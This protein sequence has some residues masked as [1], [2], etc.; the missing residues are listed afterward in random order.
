MRQE[1]VHQLR[2]EAAASLRRHENRRANG[3][4]A[5]SVLVGEADAG[6][7]CWTDWIASQGRSAIDFD[8]SSPGIAAAAV[9]AVWRSHD[10]LSA[11]FR[12]LG[13]RTGHDAAQLRAEWSV[14]TGAEQALWLDRIGVDDGPDD[15]DRFCRSLLTRSE[16]RS[17]HSV[18]WF[19]EQ[20]GWTA[21]RLLGAICLIV[22]ADELPAFCLVWRA[23]SSEQLPSVADE[24]FEIASAA[25]R[26]PVSLLL[27]PAAKAA[28][29]DV[30]HTSRT[31]AFLREGVIDLSEWSDEGAVLPNDECD[32]A[33]ANDP[34]RRTAEPV[35]SRAEDDAA[36]SA[37]ERFLFEVLE[38]TPATTGLFA[39]N[40]KLDF[41]FGGSQAAEIDLACPEFKLAIEIDGYYHFLDPES[42]RRDR[43]KDLELQ[44]RG[45]LV[46]RFLADDVGPRQEEI[47]A[48][49][50]SALQLRRESQR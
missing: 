28:V 34:V 24:L 17:S 32:I 18:S 45:W 3:C 21:A 23:E 4:P 26:L 35:G 8:A 49:V 2:P 36:R 48:A 47:V 37:A 27:P 7:R 20:L 22:P 16:A 38:A 12:E 14:R 29:V 6:R 44:R 46:M 19:E 11:A 50:T 33:A 25:P 43:R 40:V 1:V 30:G 41:S 10:V 15:R 5:V 39:L 9:T 31:L 42:Y 13:L